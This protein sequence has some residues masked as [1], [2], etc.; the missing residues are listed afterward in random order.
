MVDGMRLPDNDPSTATAA[1]EDWAFSVRSDQLDVANRKP[2]ISGFMR[3]RNEI[4][5]VDQ[6]IA[7]HLPFLDELVILDNNSTD[8]TWEL[9]QT[10]AD[11]Y[12]A[13]I[14]AYRYKPL[15]HPVGTRQTRDLP[16]DHPS[17]LANYYNYALA[18]TQHR[19]AI[20]IDGDHV[21]IPHLFE[22][23]RDFALAHVNLSTFVSIFGVNLVSNGNDLFIANDFYFRPAPRP[24][25]KRIGMSPFTH[26]DHAF[27]QVTECSW[28]QVDPWHAY[29]VMPLHRIYA[30]QK[31]FSPVCFLHLKNVKQDR[32]TSNWRVAEYRDSIRKEW[33]ENA[34]RFRRD[35]VMSLS[36]ARRFFPA[37][38]KGADIAGEVVRLNTD[39]RVVE[40]DGIEPKNLKKLLVQRRVKHYLLLIRIL[41][42]R[43]VNR[44]R[45]KLGV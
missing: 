7:S 4:T 36:E 40:R 31:R 39:Y 42:K 11:R 24:D 30:R 22:K 33:E 16:T 19:I 45:W 23:A 6:S 20:K 3:L 21:A 8:G 38:L 29:E 18:L 14:R 37:Y 15:V 12:P 43:I 32:G 1:V 44:L 9:A 35:K 17:S 2:G 28:H 25:Q 13:K 26:G 10:W 41:V 27:F 34:F 5:F